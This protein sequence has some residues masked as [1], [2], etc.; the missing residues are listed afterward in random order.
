VV[1][2][3]DIIDFLLTLLTDEEAQAEFDKD[4]QGALA[5]AGLEGVSAAD[6]RDARLQLAD[7]G[8]ISATDDGRG[9]SYPDGDD[10][11]REIGYTTQHYVADEHAGYGHTGHDGGQAD[12]SLVDRS[13]TID[14]RDTFFFQSISDDDVT[15]EQDNS[16][17][18]QVAVQDNDVNVSDDDTTINAE[19][20]FNSDNDLVAIQDNDVN[21]G[22]EVIDVDVTGGVTGEPDEPTE[23]TEPG[24]PAVDP[25]GDLAAVSGPTDLDTEEPDPAEDPAAVSE[26]ADPGLESEPVEPDPVADVAD[27][28]D[29]TADD[30][31]ADDALP[32]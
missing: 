5:D 24:E 19:D 17:N 20:S 22:D 11:V 18:T 12:L 26:L 9:S 1:A 8:A 14:D 27:A 4:P 32:V 15:I 28:E 23:P 7:S 13:V 21:G 10:P 2:F 16:V 29:L 30:L 3:A 31:T 25:A 6:I